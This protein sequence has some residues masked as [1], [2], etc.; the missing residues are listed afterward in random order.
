MMVDKWCFSNSIIP[1]TCICWPST[2]NKSFIFFQL[3]ISVC[4]HVFL[5]YSLSYKSW[6]S[7]FILMLKL[8]HSW[9][10]KATSRQPLCLFDLAHHSLSTSL[11]FGLKKK[12][13]VTNSSFSFPCVAME[14]AS[15]LRSVFFECLSG[16]CYLEIKI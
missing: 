12:K 5:Y 4:V 16:E 1:C 9:P 10:G 14:S 8:S 2:V 6:L 11:L 13:S 7:L 3:F 15:S